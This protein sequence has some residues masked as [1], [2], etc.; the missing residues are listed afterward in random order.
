MHEFEALSGEILNAAIK[1]HK[2]LGPG[3]IEA[4][5]KKALCVELKNRGIPYTD[6]KVEVGTHRLDLVVGDAGDQIIVEV[7]AVKELNTQPGSPV[8]VLFKSN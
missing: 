6:K 4:I 3:F 1:V 2:T 8:I 7:K 5:Y